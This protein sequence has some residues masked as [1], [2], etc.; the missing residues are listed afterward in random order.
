MNYNLLISSCLRRVLVAA[1]ALAVTTAPM[2]FAQDDNPFGEFG[3]TSEAEDTP[4]EE[5]AEGGAPAVR[6]PAARPAGPPRVDAASTLADFARRD[7]AVAAVLDLPRETPAQKF[8]AVTM[9]IDLGHPDVAGLLLP[10]LLQAP[11]DDSQR[12]ALVREFGTARFLR[13]IRLDSPAAPGP[14]A[15]LRAFAQACLDAASAEARDPARI[16]ALIAQLHAPTEEERYAARV[17]L[18]STGEPGMIAAFS[19]LSAATTEDARANIML[20]L[21]EMRPMVNE[22]L[23]AVLADAQ[24]TLRRDAAELA[25]HLRL[26]E[27]MPLLVSIAVSNDAAAAAAARAA[28]TKL[29]MPAPTANEAQALLRQRLEAMPTEPVAS[30]PDDVVAAWWSWDPESRQLSVA[31]YPISQVRALKAARLS[32]ALI[33]AG[34]TVNPADVRHTVLYSLEEAALLGRQPSQSLTQAIAAMSPADLSAAL[35]TATEA[36]LHAAAIQLCAELARRKDLSILATSDGRPSPLAAALKSRDRAVRFAALSAIM[37]LAPPRSFPG[38]SYVTDAL[39]YFV[40]GAGQPTAI[41]ASSDIVE[42]SNWAGQLRGLGYE[43][44]SVRTGREAILAAIDP[45]TSARLGLIMLDSDI[46]QPLIGEVVYQLRVADRTASVPILIASSVP[47]LATAQRIEA[48]DPLVLAAPRPHGKESF[49]TLIEQT[50]TLRG[51]PM[52]PPEERTAQAAQAL[53][54]LAELISKGAPYDELPRDAALVN[55]T[56]LLPDLAA[57]SIA[58]LAALG[59]VESQAALVDYASGHALP[60]EARR[61]AANAFATSVAKHGLRLGREEVLWQYDRYNASETADAD[62]QQVLGHILD[63]IEKKP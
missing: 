15:G 45:A 49:A 2:A 16:T 32:R 43:A 57:P 50:V 14:L 56:L 41:T 48:N 35:A 20:A 25:G 62:T 13:L 63:V 7:A 11:I 55:R 33:A 36:G 37:Q 8:R 5:A 61:A 4:P 17:D 58:V 44:T 26:E 3:D 59:S 21:A 24:G 54:W 34:G 42:A 10:E 28:L 46:G 39:W 23:L 27:A 40:A 22:P 53:A 18:R 38:A 31:E 29:G 12:A 19:A 9:L 60:I 51:G 6:A 30:S 47:R 1:M 52:T